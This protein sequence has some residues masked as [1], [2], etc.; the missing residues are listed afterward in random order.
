[1]V[2]QFVHSTLSAAIQNFEQL[3]FTDI[4]ASLQL[5]YVLGEGNFPFSTNFHWNFI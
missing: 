3:S 1:M 5:L 2:A 4:E